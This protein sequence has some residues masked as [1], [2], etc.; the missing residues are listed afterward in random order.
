MT[1]GTRARWSAASADLGASSGRLLLGRFDGERLEVEEIHRFENEPVQIAATLYWDFP[2]LYLEILHGLRRAFSLCAGRGDSPPRSLGIVTWGVDFGLLDRNGALLSLPV[3]YRDRR[4]EGM[5]REVHA[6]VSPERLYA[7]TGLQHLP[8]NTLFQVMALRRRAPWT[9]DSAA[10]LLFIPDLLHFCL[11]GERLTEYT[12]ASTSQLLDVR[13]RVW[14]EELLEALEFPREVFQPLLAPGTRL[15]PLRPEAREQA[16]GALEVI[17]AATHD[18]ASAVA[19]AP[20][21]ASPF[22]FLSSGTWSLL[23]AELPEPDLSASARAANFTNEGGAGGAIRFLKNIMGLWPLQELRREWEREG[24]ALSW[25]ALA[26]EAGAAP[27]PGSWVDPDDPR[28]LAPGPMAARVRAALAETGQPAPESG[29]VMARLLLESLALKCAQV[30]ERLETVTARRF[31][32]LHIV[33]GGVRNA[34]LCQWTADALG[35][36]VLAGPEEAT[37]LGNLLIQ[38]LAAGKIASLAE[39][40]ALIARSFP[41]V[42]YEPRAQEGARWREAR[43]RF[44]R[45]FSAA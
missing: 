2:R 15:G 43:E 33:G 31:E 38:L 16:G 29:G 18:T 35:R 21:A 32:A 10:A 28:F 41:P 26:R 12:I 4:V 36:P 6:R 42:V 19:A 7:I 27:P 20:A 24:R 14:S 11:T 39:G 9:L 1:K 34:L 13:A 30:F 23:G 5:D 45:L 3:H 44:D 37:A 17:A 8:F 22:A 25:E 40:R